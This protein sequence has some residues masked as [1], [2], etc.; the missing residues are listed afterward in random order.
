MGTALR[1]LPFALLVAFLALA[2]GRIGDG[3]L[4]LFG[5]VFVVLTLATMWNLLAGYAGLMS[6]GHQAYFGIGGY[7]LFLFSNMTG[8]HPFVALLAAVL[9][10]GLVAAVIAPLLFRLRDAYFAIGSWVLAE[11]IAIAVQ[12]TD[13]LGGITGV[14]LATIGQIDF[15]AF[16]GQMFAVAGAAALLSV[17]GVFLLLRAR[18]GLAMMSVRDN[19]V[20]AAAVGVNVWSNRFIAY[21]LS[22]AGCGLAGG[23]S[24]L[25]GLAVQPG[26]AFSADWTVV[27]TFVV[28]VGGLGTLEGPIVGTVVYFVLRQLLTVVFPLTGTWYLVAMGLIAVVTML[29][30]P[31]G[32]WPLVADRLHLR[33]LT[34]QRRFPELQQNRDSYR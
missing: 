5:E 1:I 25:S 9:L 14:S 22:A 21:A 13:A 32:L 7:A 10:P 28:V 3:T 23:I 17:G 31:Q 15:V 4:H 27:M 19:E 20:A 30:A 24:L 8:V 12:K 29:F 11:V 34:V 16:E 2:P 26:N 18:I 33:W 6:L